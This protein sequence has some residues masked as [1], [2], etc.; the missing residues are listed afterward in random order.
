MLGVRRFRDTQA[1]MTVDPGRGRGV[2]RSAVQRGPGRGL[3]G[4]LGQYRTGMAGQRVAVLM[5]GVQGATM[6]AGYAGCETLHQIACGFS[7]HWCAALAVAFI[8]A[9]V[10][11]V[12]LLRVAD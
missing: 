10:V 1:M 9:D 6:A 12:S 2:A 8:A 7:C 11:N 5:G 3:P 4:R